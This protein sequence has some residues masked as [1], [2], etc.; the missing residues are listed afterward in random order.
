M[1]DGLFDVLVLASDFLQELSIEIV[2][3]KVTAA[4]PPIPTNNKS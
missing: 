3:M 2:E 4:N 1:I